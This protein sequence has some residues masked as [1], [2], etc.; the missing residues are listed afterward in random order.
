MRPARIL[1]LRGGA[2][3]DFIVT[4][5]ALAALR[6]RWPEGYLELVGYPHVATL[7]LEAG[8]VNRVVSLHGAHIARFFS[9]RPDFPDDLVVWIRSFDFILNYLHDPDGVVVDNLKRAGARTVLYGSPLVGEDHA[10]DHFLK[11]LESLAIYARGASAV[12]DLGPA[13]AEAGRQLAGSH[14]IAGPF[15]VLHPGS[16]SPRKNW[17]ADRFVELARRLRQGTG[18][19]PLLLTGEADEDVAAKIAALAPDLLR[20][21]SLP[22]LSVAHLLSAATRYVGNDSGISHLAA[23][24]GAPA[25]V[26]FG[27]SDPAR[28]A[29]RGKQVCL[30]Q[31]P[32]GEL[33]RLEVDTV[34][35]TL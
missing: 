8:L 10:V 2:L 22:L 21:S 24:V 7:A 20:I 6:G 30:I 11:P 25:T 18:W 28:W 31:A 13:A 9:L 33:N 19:T 16:G 1:I 32:D 23:A 17:P 26:L 14:G 27:P 4:L 5:P 29:P 3:G 15:A 35:R 12:L 34:F